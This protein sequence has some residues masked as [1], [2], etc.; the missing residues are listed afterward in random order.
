MPRNDGFKFYDARRFGWMQIAVTTTWS[1][2]QFFKF[3]VV[4]Q[5]LLKLIALSF[6]RYRLV[7]Q[8]KGYTDDVPL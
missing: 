4:I 7:A 6:A 5:S 3:K 1:R 2:L 8:P